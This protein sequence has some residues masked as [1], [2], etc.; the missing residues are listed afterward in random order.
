VPKCGACELAKARGR[1]TQVQHGDTS[2]CR[3]EALRAQN[4]VPGQVVSTDQ[5]E[6]RTPGRLANTFG[7]EKE[8]MRYN[9]GAIYVDHATKL[10]YITNQ[11]SLH[12][13]EIICGK[14][15]FEKHASEYGIKIRKYHADN[16]VFLSEAY[17][18]HCENRDQTLDYSGVGAHHQNQN[19]VAERVIQTVTGSVR[20][21]ASADAMQEKFCW[22]EFALVVGRLVAAA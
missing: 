13:G 22:D 7:K 16:E 9:G 4:L 19:A 18:N 14:E 2:D 15:Q 17:K 1:V 20:Y 5:Y 8:K 6:T 12:A 21:R 3:Q 10:I 11:V